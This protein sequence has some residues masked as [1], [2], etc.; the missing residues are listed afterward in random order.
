MWVLR[1]RDRVTGPLRGKG[2]S[3]VSEMYGR[4]HYGDS[5]L[6]ILLD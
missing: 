2:S 3:S 5:E 1:R 6:M 4:F